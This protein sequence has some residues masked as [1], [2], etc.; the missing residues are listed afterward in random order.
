MFFLIEFQPYKMAMAE[1]YTQPPAVM[2]SAHLEPKNTSI[3]VSHIIP[4]AVSQA[5]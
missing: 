4:Q 3:P 1:E 5:K 2:A